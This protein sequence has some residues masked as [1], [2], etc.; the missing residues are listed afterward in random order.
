MFS[1]QR[2][3]DGNQGVIINRL[4]C[5]SEPLTEI[6]P[7]PHRIHEAGELDTGQF[8]RQRLFPLR[9]VKI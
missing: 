3:S 4:G 1:H 5:L 8:A 7:E 2:P 6:T 9:L